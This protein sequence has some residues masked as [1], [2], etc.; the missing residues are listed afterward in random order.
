MSAK[1][2]AKSAAKEGGFWLTVAIVAVVAPTLLK[3]GASKLPMPEGLRTV[4]NAA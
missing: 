3:I 4:I 1:S 2:R